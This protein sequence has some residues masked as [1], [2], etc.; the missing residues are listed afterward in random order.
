MGL[1]LGIVLPQDLTD[2]I[3]LR[4]FVQ[5]IDELG[6]DR[7][8]FPDHVIG[9]NPRSHVVNGP[10][11]HESYFH[12]LIATMGF[13]AAVTR[14][15]RL[16]SDVAIL[17]QRQAGLFAKQMA[18]IDV[19][20]N[21][22]AIA[23]IGGGWNQVEFEVL[24]MDFADRGR[25]LDEQI[26]VL[27]QLWCNELVDFEGEFHTIVDAGIC[28]LPVQKPIP[29]WFGGWSDVMI[30][31]IARSGD[32]WL[33]Y[34]PLEAGAGE[35]IDKLRESCAA[36]GRDPAEIAV[37]SWIFCNRS[38]VMAGANQAP[39]AHEIRSPDEWV[40]EALAWQALGVSHIDCW[41]MYGGFTKADQHIALA[42]QFKDVM[43]SI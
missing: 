13:V 34:L 1:K 38:D 22:R 36:V 31:R 6:F 40:R 28:P 30:R 20:S 26:D 41:T 35:R 24:G 10:Y 43:D 5:A 18:A 2:P 39:D 12:E 11:T 4:D 15:V 21:G 37:T 16:L 42:Q 23:G 33:L 19:L 8:G 27:R 9:A 25:R 7:I 14:N 29:I 3:E 17:P 32:G